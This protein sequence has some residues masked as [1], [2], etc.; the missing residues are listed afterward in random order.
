[1]SV[2]RS[3]Y[4]II[5]GCTVTDCGR[6]RVENPGNNWPA[7]ISLMPDSNYG[8][9]KNNTVYDN[10]GEG[11]GLYRESDNNIVEDN[12]THGNY[13]AGIYLEKSR[14]NIARNNLIY[15]YMSS[16]PLS[17]GVGLDDEPGSGGYSQDNVI[18]GN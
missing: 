4:V 17:L 14:G 5:D 12:F 2:Y 11:I 6:I 7:S 13:K 10:H 16:S 3:D 9:V 8:W 1:L 15:G 18:H